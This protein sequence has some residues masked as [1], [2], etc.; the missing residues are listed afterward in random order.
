MTETRP[1]YPENVGCDRCLS[2]PAKYRVLDDRGHES[3]VC[4]NECAPRFLPVFED[5]RGNQFDAEIHDRP[6]KWDGP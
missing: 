4:C 6:A 5:A 2:R 1:P 3:A